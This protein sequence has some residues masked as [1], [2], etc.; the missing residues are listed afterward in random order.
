MALTPPS[1]LMNP[2]AARTRQ[3]LFDAAAQL[4]VAQGYES[5]TMA[6]IAAAAGTSRRT[7]FNYFPNKGDIPMLWVR[8][9]ADHAIE[10]VQDAPCG[11]VAERIHAYFRAIS[12]AVESE[13]ELSRQMMLGWTAAL[14][15]T[16]YESQLLADVTPLLEEGQR[17]GRIGQGVDV[18][19]AARALSDVLQGA[20]FRWVREPGTVLHERV[21]SVIGL[22]LRAAITPTPDNP[23]GRP[24]GSGRAD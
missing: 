16:L 6:A 9:M 3:A 11:D 17:A 24:T 10:Q 20:V 12:E 4:F 19:V 8:Q 2:R 22:V 7:A 5:T 13:P 15:P 21:D 1:R 18:A 23:S 14:G